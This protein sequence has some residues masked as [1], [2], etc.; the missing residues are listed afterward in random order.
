MLHYLR[1]PKHHASIN[2]ALQDGMEG[3]TFSLVWHRTVANLWIEEFDVWSEPSLR[4][5]QMPAERVS[6][7]LPKFWAGTMSIGDPEH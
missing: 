3:T 5:S 7:S 2:C 1:I 6:G 4:G